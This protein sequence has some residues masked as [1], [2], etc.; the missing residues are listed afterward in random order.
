MMIL[1]LISNNKFFLSYLKND[2][3]FT[4][5]ISRSLIKFYLPISII[6]LI[7]TLAII[8][9]VINAPQ[10]RKVIIDKKNNPYE[11]K[12]FTP[13]VTPSHPAH[14]MVKRFYF[15]NKS[16][17][18]KLLQRKTKSS[19]KQEIKKDEIKNK[20]K[21]LNLFCNPNCKEKFEKIF[22]LIQQ[23]KIDI[24]KIDWT[25]PELKE[26]GIESEN[27]IKNLVNYYFTMG[28]MQGMQEKSG[29]EK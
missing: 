22:N 2:V 20:N 15:D 4:N 18:N 8:T 19:F 3:I 17:Q 23:G 24:N 7:I 5:N 21:S 29:E 25:Q 12:N 28:Y 14:L 10:I 1:F 11:H 6:T 13:L 27:I 26:G 9:M 16:L